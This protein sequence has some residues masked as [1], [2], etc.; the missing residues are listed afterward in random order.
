MRSLGACVVDEFF[1]HFRWSHLPTVGRYGRH[2]TFSNKIYSSIVHDNASV[3]RGLNGRSHPG[4]CAIAEPTASQA[5]WHG[6]QIRVC[7]FKPLLCH[8]KDPVVAAITLKLHR[9]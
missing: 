6:Q 1:W 2:R 4:S 8:V 5:M 3:T 7:D 9:V